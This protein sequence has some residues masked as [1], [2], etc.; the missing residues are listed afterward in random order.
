MTGTPVLPAGP[1][2]GAGAD[3]SAGTG[4][5]DGGTGHT[6]VPAT[7][8][9]GS[10]AADRDSPRGRLLQAAREVLAADGLEGLTLRAIAR[11]AGVSHGAPLRHFPSLASLLAALAA[12]G[13]AGLMTAV[14]AAVAAT[15]A[16][17]DAAGTLVSPR[18]RLADAGRA[19]VRHAVAD[20]GV[21]T[22]MFRHERVD[23]SDPD[24][25]EQGVAAF[26]Q[27]AA[28]VANAQRDG[29][30]PD[31]DTTELAAVLWANVHGLAELAIHGALG[32]VG[33][34]AAER[35][36]VLSTELA[37]GLDP[38]PAPTAARAR[39]SDGRP[40][41]PTTEEIPT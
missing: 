28:L 6:P 21:F 11:R 27:L 34:D 25:Q 20:P 4:T 5:P 31:D 40:D 14:D 1:R 2:P 41:H 26:Q 35:L 36:P 23:V 38:D 18:R 30:R 29:W 16:A 39:P 8:A 13:F 24:Y 12:E 15:G 37:L 9:G 19:Y 17:A 32:I 3:A 7:A 10:P 33:P 22:V